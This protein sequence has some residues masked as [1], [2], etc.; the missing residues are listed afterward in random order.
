MEIPSE[1]ISMISGEQGETKQKAARLVVDLAS[2]SGAKEFI[3]CNNSH[4][5]GVSV[6]T[7]GHGLRTF[8]SDLS[9]DPD[10]QVAIPTTLNSAGCDH[11]KMDEM[12]IEYPDFLK[13]QFEI[14]HAYMK[15]GIKTYCI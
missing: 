2:V 6:L 3:R 5:S 9:S 8:L 13:Q 10:G 12:D 11:E 14:I 1:L 4:V 15:L 7:G